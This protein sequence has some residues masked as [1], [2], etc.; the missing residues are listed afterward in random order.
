MDPLGSRRPQFSYGALNIQEV[1]TLLPDFRA[2]TQSHLVGFP[3]TIGRVMGPLNPRVGKS[4]FILAGQGSMYQYTVMGNVLC[5]FP[6]PDPLKQRDLHVLV[7]FPL[8]RDNG[9]GGH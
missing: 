8:L 9:W 7:A 5:I 6:A 4:F 1:G 2:F 3:P